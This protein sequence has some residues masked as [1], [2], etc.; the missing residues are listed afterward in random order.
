MSNIENTTP[1]DVLAD[2]VWSGTHWH[3]PN[4]EKLIARI[5]AL[6]AELA[7]AKEQIERERKPWRF[8]LITLP[9]LRK[10]EPGDYPDLSETYDLS[11]VDTGH[12]E[13]VY[14]LG[15]N[16]LDKRLM[17]A[18][19]QLAAANATVEKCKAAGFIDEQGNVRKVLGTLPITADNCIVGSNCTIWHPKHGACV[20]RSDVDSGCWAMTSDPYSPSSGDLFLVEECYSAAEAAREGKGQ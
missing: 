20:C 2:R 1:I 12:G 15:S 10:Q 18:E 8:H 11:L 14:V 7:E 13:R 5:T 19:K 16:E 9:V 4:I 3:Y 17:E 6:E